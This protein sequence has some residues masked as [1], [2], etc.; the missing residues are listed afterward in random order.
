MYEKPEVQNFSG[1]HCLLVERD[2][3]LILVC[4]AAIS[5]RLRIG[6]IIQHTDGTTLPSHKYIG[7]GRV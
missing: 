6:P 4:L 1:T 3:F 2:K 7:H 5:R